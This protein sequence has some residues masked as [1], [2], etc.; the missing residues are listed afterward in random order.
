VQALSRYSQNLFQPP[1]DT[2]RGLETNAWLS[3]LEPVKPFA[4]EGTE[5]KGFQLWGGQNL[6]FTPRSDAEFSAADLKE[7]ARYPLAR[8]AI[9]NVK[10][11][12]CKASCQIQYRPK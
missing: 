4:P 12:L 5:P 8:V 11:S 6:T 7:M 10:D 9:E 3:P 2:I 1:D